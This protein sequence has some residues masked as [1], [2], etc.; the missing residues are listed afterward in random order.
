MIILKNRTESPLLILE[1]EFEATAAVR[2]F[3]TSPP[4]ARRE[5]RCFPDYTHTY[6]YI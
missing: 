2:L 5:A 1:L 3:F 6:I 4:P